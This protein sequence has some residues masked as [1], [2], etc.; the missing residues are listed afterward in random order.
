MKHLGRNYFL[1]A[2][3]VFQQQLPHPVF[4]LVT[5]DTEWAAQ[6]IPRG[7]RPYFTGFHDPASQVSNSKLK[8]HEIDVSI[9]MSC[10][11]TAR[12][13]TWPSSPSAATPSSPAAHSACGGTSSAGGRA[14]YQNTSAGARGGTRSRYTT[15][16]YSCYSL[17]QVATSL[18]CSQVPLLD[19]SHQWMPAAARARLAENCPA[20]L[21]LQP[22]N[23]TLE[24]HTS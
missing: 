12:D 7:F 11:R 9:D 23:N 24:H 14:F 1:R 8:I 21:Q 13:W 4:V 20:C 2:M 16:Y 17:D 10:C 19:L 15:R 18:L 22:S 6:Q 3:E 5:D